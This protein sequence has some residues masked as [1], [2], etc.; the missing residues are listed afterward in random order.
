MSQFRRLRNWSLYAAK[1]QMLLELEVLGIRRDSVEFGTV[2][3][4][5]E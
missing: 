1:L 3:Q 2:G 5:I 4:N